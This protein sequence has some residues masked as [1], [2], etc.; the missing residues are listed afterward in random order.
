MTLSAALICLISNMLLLRWFSTHFARTVANAFS[1]LH[2]CLSITMDESF[3]LDGANQNIASRH[4]RLLD[5]LLA[6]SVQLDLAYS[7]AAFELRLG[8]LSVASIKPLIAV[9]ENTR[10][11]LSWGSLRVKTR[12]GEK[13]LYPTMTPAVNLG[14]VILESMKHVEATL[15][16][17]FERTA[18]TL[19]PKPP[20]RET[21]TQILH[22]LDQA[23][24][25]AREMFAGLFR[26]MKEDAPKNDY[27]G[28]AYDASDHFLF[29]VSL[30][31]MANEMRRALLVANKIL[32]LHNTSQT[33]VWYP[34][35]SWAWL[36][37]APPTVIGDDRD[38]VMFDD[39]H[40]ERF[41]DEHRLSVTEAREGLSELVGWR[42]ANLSKPS[43]SKFT[44]RESLQLRSIIY[45]PR[46]TR[47]RF[48]FAACIRSI[49]HSSHL[50]HAVKNSIGV[51]LLSLPA[52]LSTGSQGQ[53]WFNQAHGQ[54]M[55]I[56]YVWV[57][58][59]NTGA[60]WRVASL[61]IVRLDLVV[62]S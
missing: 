22:R 2:E 36:G 18:G 40:P 8:R 39:H 15:L 12:R 23:R 57:L 41:E 51:M 46:I 56:S 34:R 14:Q 4:K 30:I 9:V 28:L 38:R 33:R 19:G 44:S 61:R 29:L 3:S 52:F 13:F 5:Q 62:E 43:L 21:S 55:I 7:I 47:L 59:T 60:T 54:W 58:E 31:E 48:L 32:D 6:E 10:R 49:R 50:Q 25:N 11:E 24:D 53:R 26:G 16:Y 27:M 17:V 1:D 35:L 42:E 37:I 45:G 20:G